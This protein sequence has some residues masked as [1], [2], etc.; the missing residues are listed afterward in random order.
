MGDKCPVTDD[1]RVKTGLGTRPR[2]LIACQL[3]V[4]GVNNLPRVV[5]QPRRAAPWRP[6]DGAVRRRLDDTGHRLS[7]GSRSRTD[8][9]L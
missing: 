3:G 4:I 5:T 6:L 7:V 2:G 1:E 9:E 8:A